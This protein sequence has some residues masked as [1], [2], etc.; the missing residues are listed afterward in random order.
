MLSSF[1]K[2]G[3]AG[4]QWLCRAFPTSCPSARSWYPKDAIWSAFFILPSFLFD[5][6]RAFQSTSCLPW[7]LP[8]QPGANPQQSPGSDAHLAL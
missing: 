7:H 1:S 6:P 4:W 3:Y 8:A 2:W 5:I